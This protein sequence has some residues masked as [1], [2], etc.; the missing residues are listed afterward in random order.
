MLET[1]AALR[2]KIKSAMA[3]PA[4][5][6]SLVVLI[7]SAIILFVVP[8]FKG[9]YAELHGTLPLPTEI[10]IQ[11]SN[12]AVK[13]F[14]PILILVVVGVVLFRRWI[15][16]DQGRALW[17]ITLLKVPIFGSLIRKTAISR[18]CS[19]FS[20][21][22]K[23]GVPVLEALD[24]TR[25]TVNNVV[26]ERAVDAMADGVRRGEPIGANLES[27]PVFP[28]MVTQMIGV[29]E[30]TGALDQMLGRSSKFLEEEIER[31]VESLTSLL[32]PMLIVILG[33]AVG[34]MV[35]CLYLPM[36][37]VDTLINNGT[38]G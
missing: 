30:E 37:K 29:G 20:S 31:M 18:F 32:E 12:I 6:L 33:G 14:I 34:S 38:N 11:I 3:Y 17:H 13:L 24:I 1:Q 7:A 21:L 2:G 4:A 5:V 22:L 25:D 27:H 26:V 9:I 28:A 35:I 8:V 10:L 19:T 16:T 36:F 23:A 15:K